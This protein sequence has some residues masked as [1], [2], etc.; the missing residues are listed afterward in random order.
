MLLF[1]GFTRLKKEGF[2]NLNSFCSAFSR[3]FERE[4]GKRSK[5][6]LL[7]LFLIPYLFVCSLC[8]VP[9]MFLDFRPLIGKVLSGVNSI[10]PFEIT[11]LH[12]RIALPFLL[13]LPGLIILRLFR[14][15]LEKQKEIE[16]S[17]LKSQ[18]IIRAI[19]DMIFQ[20]NE[21]GDFLSYKGALQDLY[22]AP[23]F[24]IERNVKD[25]LPPNVADTTLKN[26]NKTL[27][28]G[29][30]V[31]YDYQLRIRNK[32][33][34][35]EC[36]LV[37]IKKNNVLG[38]VRNITEQKRAEAAIT[39]EKERLA[40]T[41]QAIGDGVISA[42]TKGDIIL[43]NRMA[44]EITEWTE[45]EAIGRPINQVISIIDTES[46]KIIN[47][48]ATLISYHDENKNMKSH[49][50]LMTKNNN[51]KYIDLNCAL[52]YRMNG[53]LVGIVMVFRDVTE[54][55]KMQ[56]S[57]VRA[58]KLETAGR[59]AG[60]I[61]H[62]FNNLLGPLV[63]YPDFIRSKLSKDH[64]VLKYL[65]TMEQSAMQM[66]EINQELLTLARRGHYCQE[67]FDLNGIIAQIIENVNPLPGDITIETSLASNLDKVKG[68]TSQ[69]SRVILNVIK[70]AIDA[71]ET[72]G[73]K[74]TIKTENFDV[75]EIWHK[76]R[77]VPEG[78][79]VKLTVSDTGCGIPKKLQREIFE[80]FFT[81]KTADGLRGTGLG[82]SVVYNVIEDHNAFLD[83]S[84]QTDEGTSFYLYFQPTKERVGC[85]VEKKEIAGG[86]EKILVVDDNPIQR[87]IIV[88]TL[89]Q[90]GYQLISVDD[91]DKA[92]ELLVG[93]RFDLLILDMRIDPEMDGTEIFRKSLEFN[94]QQ[95]AIILS[96]Y[97]DSD[98]MREAFQLG[99]MEY[100]KKPFT[101]KSILEAVRNALDNTYRDE[102]ISDEN[103]S[104]SDLPTISGAPNNRLNSLQIASTAVDNEE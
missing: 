74:L 90:Y 67:P 31:K 81:T 100:L 52:M 66:A 1:P 18:A 29:E 23:E 103:D 102:R 92:L 69:I 85:D 95:R 9:Y 28:S 88:E 40:V 53:E 15:Q 76:Y 80:P 2:E 56:E 3:N 24:F 54:T 41:L 97:A 70:N 14:K 16:D 4:F 13:L 51:E 60:E 46:Q 71:M 26:I 89:S 35:F 42:D 22:E 43:L 87:A 45:E 55:M 93:D 65:Q 10:L 91:P 78:E 59:L 47:D 30:M 32:P 34:F 58:Q 79:Y 19:P 75:N 68:G 94:P 12:L 25:V 48:P 8:I 86:S 37:P 73:G 101:V 39:W 77:K 83:F 11:I 98:R 21:R 17:F 27:S 6:E 7:A 64:P 36:R 62:D 104:D 96:G 5:F 72:N 49:T 99:T 61:A 33:R 20:L 38:I 50:V 57:L 84:S 63:A 44:E 82:L